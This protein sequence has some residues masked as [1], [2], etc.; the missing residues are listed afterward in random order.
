MSTTKNCGCSGSNELAESRVTGKPGGRLTYYQRIVGYATDAEGDAAWGLG[1][2]YSGEVAGSSG[3]LSGSF[4]LTVDGA[5]YYYKHSAILID[6]Y[7]MPEGG[8][9]YS[10]RGSYELYRQTGPDGVAPKSSS[11]S[12]RL[13]FWV[14]GT[15]YRTEFA[16][17]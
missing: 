17:D 4:V 7:Q 1:L 10:F 5:S 3:S 16:L 6:K 8:Y 11:Y 14:D 12:V 2:D 15:L 13:I 9:A